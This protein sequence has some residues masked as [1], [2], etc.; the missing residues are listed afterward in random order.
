VG[1][2]RNLAEIMPATAGELRRLLGEW[3]EGEEIEIPAR[4]S[5]EISLVRALCS[6][7]AFSDSM[8]EEER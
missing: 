4:A 5:A 8:P 6:I 2:S 7:L 1:E 3:R